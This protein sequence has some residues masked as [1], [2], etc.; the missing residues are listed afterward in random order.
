LNYRRNELKRT[1]ES[2]LIFYQRDT[3]RKI[4]KK[5][6]Q[7]FTDHS[8][9]AYKIYAKDIL[10]RKNSKEAYILYLKREKVEADKL[11][12]QIELYHFLFLF[13]LFLFLLNAI[14]FWG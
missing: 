10:E 1:G 7:A 11:R 5:F 2:D 9:E 13:M 4:F 6:E 3:R 8:N 14:F 12:T